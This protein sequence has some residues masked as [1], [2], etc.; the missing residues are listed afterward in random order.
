M[1]RRPA[2][3]CGGRRPIARPGEPGGDTWG[4]LPLTFRAGSDAWITGSYDRS[5]ESRLLG[6]GAGQAVGASR[7]RDRRRGALHELDA[8]ARSRYRKDEVVL[9]AP[10]GRV[11]RHGRS[12]RERPRR[13]RRTQVAVQDG[14]ARDSLAARS[15]ERRVHPR[16]RPRLPDARRRRPANRAR[17]R[18]APERSRRSA[19][20]STGVPAPR[21][22]R[23]GARCRSVRRRMRSTC[24]SA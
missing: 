6:H 23:A 17:S 19:W 9:S 2:K 4:D 13:Y 18:I 3:S 5:R 12:V 22:S 15:R 7:S 14:Q 21:G 10:A 1:M 11:A 24:R 16:D 8:R 20:R